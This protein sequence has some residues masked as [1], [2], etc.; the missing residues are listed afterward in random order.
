MFQNHLHLNHESTA[1]VFKSYL[2]S[3]TPYEDFQN[4]LF[5]VSLYIQLDCSLGK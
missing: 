2:M 4:K 5:K 3:K 1:V